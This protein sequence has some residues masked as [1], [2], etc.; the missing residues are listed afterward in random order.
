MSIFD[1][2]LLFLLL[3]GAYKGFRRGLMLEIAGLI[4]FLLGIYLGVRF[5][6]EGKALLAGFTD[7]QTEYLPYAAFLLLFVVVVVGVHLL[8]YLL[9]K[10]LDMTLLGTFDNLAGAFLGLLKFAFAI[11]LLLW[12]LVRLQ[13]ILP[14]EWLADSVVYDY[15]APVAP[16]V[17]DK[18]AVWLP[19]LQE[20]WQGSVA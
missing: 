13:V 18:V 10:I 20:L 9:K 14:G 7:I 4:A 6:E 15:V 3:V 1:L 8:G 12:L 19:Y 2:V 16:F 11:S 17:I 5:L